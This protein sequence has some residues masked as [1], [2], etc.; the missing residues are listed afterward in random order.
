MTE[1][2]GF[3]C[4][5]ALVR[6]LVQTNEHPAQMM[7]SS[8]ST[9]PFQTARERRELAKLAARITHWWTA[10]PAAQRRP[11]Y[12]T[13]VISSESRV[14]L[15]KAGAPL[16]YLGWQ[17]VQVRLEGICTVVWVAPGAASPLRPI[18]RPTKHTQ[19]S[20]QQRALHQPDERR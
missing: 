20:H 16:R 18:G 13:E 2:D 3:E 17:R 11:Y 4:K 1:S 10:T 19:P 12:R 6:V 8:N 14:P 9:T 15:N 7:D 5:Q